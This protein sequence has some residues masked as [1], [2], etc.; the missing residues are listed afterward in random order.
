MPKTKIYN[1]PE[2]KKN[3][4]EPTVKN[5]EK[6]TN[7]YTLMDARHVL[8]PQITFNAQPRPTTNPSRH[9]YNPNLTIS[10]I[11]DYWSAACTRKT[12]KLKAIRA[13]DFNLAF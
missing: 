10:D 9:S 12:G 8:T 3:T 1:K 4:I 7:T 2:Q 6:V 13:N 11:L 5:L